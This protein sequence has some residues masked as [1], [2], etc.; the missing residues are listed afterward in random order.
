MHLTHSPVCLN[1]STQC[2]K[3]ERDMVVPGL[4]EFIN[5][6]NNSVESEDKDT[7]HL[8]EDAYNV[9]D[10]EV[11]EVSLGVA[12][13]RSGRMKK[14]RNIFSDI[15]QPLLTQRMSKGIAYVCKPPVAMPDPQ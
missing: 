10:L 2:V 6:C 15:K 1:V 14:K 4:P 5:C 12:V 3:K 7:S 8:I 9:N 11:P 13:R